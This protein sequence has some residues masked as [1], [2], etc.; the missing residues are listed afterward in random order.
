MSEYYFWMLQDYSYTFSRPLRNSYEFW[1]YILYSFVTIVIITHD[2]N[3]Y[4]T[5]RALL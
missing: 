2:D 5:R 1:Q 3:Q 4:K